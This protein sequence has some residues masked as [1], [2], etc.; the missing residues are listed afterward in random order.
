MLSE[1]ASFVGF[2]GVATDSQINI[3][4][5]VTQNIACSNPNTEIPTGGTGDRVYDPNA[6]ED[7]E[8]EK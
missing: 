4:G 2:Y 7:D 1:E 3:L 8:D 6:R 5:L